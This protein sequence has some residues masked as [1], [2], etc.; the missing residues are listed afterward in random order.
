MYY[1]FNAFKRYTNAQQQQF[2]LTLA[3]LVAEDGE[4]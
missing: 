2:Q 3:S 4:I 1:K